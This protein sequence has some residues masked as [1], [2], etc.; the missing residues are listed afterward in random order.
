MSKT[1]SYVLIAIMVSSFNANCTNGACTT[2]DTA[3]SKCTACYGGSVMFTLNNGTCEAKT[4]AECTTDQTTA[5]SCPSSKTMTY[6]SG[7]YNCVS[8]ISNCMMTTVAGSCTGMCDKDYYNSGNACVKVSTALANCEYYMSNTQC[9]SCVGGYVLTTSYTCAVVTQTA[10]P[11]GNADTANGNK[12]K[13]C[14][15]FKVISSDGLQCEEYSNK[16]AFI[17]TSLLL[18]LSMLLF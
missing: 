4:V 6:I 7:K 3:N 1:L 15:A 2:C 12:C 8:K 11:T 14:T 18:A 16:R 10:C 17:I 9:A 5:C 13:D